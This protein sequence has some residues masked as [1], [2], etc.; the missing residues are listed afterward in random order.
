MKLNKLK[1]KLISGQSVFGIWSMI[2]SPMVANIIATSGVDFHI[3]DLEHGP[4]DLVTLESIIYAVEAAGSTPIIR[5]PNSSDEEIL[6]VLELGVNSIMMSHVSSADEARRLVSSCLYPNLGTRGLSP[7]TR[8]HDYSETNLVDKLQRSN[9][10]MLVGA[11]VEGETVISSMQEIS[12]VEN[13]D[14]VYF[15]IFDLASSMGIPGKIDDPRILRLLEKSVNILDQNGKAAGTVARDE[16]TLKIFSDIGIRFLAYRNDS[17]M[18][19]ES[20]ESGIQSFKNLK[21]K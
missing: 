16:K 19:M 10:E 18:L 8:N 2:P 21:E 1:K 4:A 6:K 11:L 17:S 14:L 13:L 9:E 15:G 5:V 3:T 20:C 7:F 12:E